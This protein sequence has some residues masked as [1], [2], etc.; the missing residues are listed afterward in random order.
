MSAKNR[1]ISGDYAGKQIVG[2][3]EHQ[4]P[5]DEVGERGDRLHGLPERHALDLI[6]KDSEDHR[7]PGGEDRQAAHGEGIAHD[8][9]RLLQPDRIVHQVLEPLQPLEIIEG[10][11]P[12]RTV[13]EKSINP[14]VKRIIGKHC[15]QNQEGQYIEELSVGPQFLLVVHHTFLPPKAGHA[16]VCFR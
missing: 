9:Q 15:H 5:A 2:Y 11:G 1:V 4:H 7:Q 13:I 12:G 3:G 10:K 6:Q 8:Q 14:S 16:F